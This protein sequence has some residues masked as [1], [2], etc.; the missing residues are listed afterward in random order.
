VTP[1]DY[2]AVR[3]TGQIQG[4]PVA[5]VAL[6]RAVDDFDLILGRTRREPPGGVRK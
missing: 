2:D 1:E 6:A 3:E 4:E 5:Y